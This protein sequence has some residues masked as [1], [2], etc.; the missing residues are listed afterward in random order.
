MSSVWIQCNCNRSTK[1]TPLCLI[2]LFIYRQKWVTIP[3]W[4]QE[5]NW[6]W[7]DAIQCSVCSIDYLQ[8]QLTVWFIW[9]WHLT[10]TQVKSWK[11]LSYWPDVIQVC[12]AWWQNIHA[13]NHALGN[14]C[15]NDKIIILNTLS[16]HWICAAVVKTISGKI[17]KG[18]SCE[19]LT[20]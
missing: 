7:G 6:V 19:I 11:V 18:I 20:P 14:K 2:S 5:L 16:Q 1:Q 12:Y 17:R 8:W 13:A 15:F 9:M 3:L 4:I 10:I